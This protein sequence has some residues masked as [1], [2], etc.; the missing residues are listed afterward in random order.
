MYLDISP[1]S[2]MAFSLP[3]VLKQVLRPRSQIDIQIVLIELVGKGHF[4]CTFDLLPAETA[5]RIFCM[6]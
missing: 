4:D 3:T 6:S 1:S 2:M 5:Q